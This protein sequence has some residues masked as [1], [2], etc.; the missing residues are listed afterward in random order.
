MSLEMIEKEIQFLRERYKNSGRLTPLPWYNRF[1]PHVD[2]IYA[3]IMLVSS[4][5][6]NGRP[7]NVIIPKEQIF[8]KDVSIRDC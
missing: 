6:F 1:I 2:E 8:D 4:D 5:R 7:N 3:E